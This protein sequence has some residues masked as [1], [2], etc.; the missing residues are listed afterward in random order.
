MTKRW[1]RYVMPVMVE[2]DCDEDEITRVV[3]LPE[4]LRE[5]RDDMGH[6]VIY[7]EKFVRRHSD[8][9][10][11]T[12]AFCVAEPRWTHD[13]LRVGPPANR[14]E[15]IEWDEGFDLTDADE[16]YAEVSPYADPRW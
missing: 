13:S 4:E 9:Q 15:T 11:Q 12:H 1:V 5:D 14:P 2:V 3:T 10:P 6:F 16:A 8:G 7:D